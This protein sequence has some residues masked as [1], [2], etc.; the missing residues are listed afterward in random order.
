MGNRGSIIGPTTQT[1]HRSQREPVSPIGEGEEK[2]APTTPKRNSVF[3]AFSTSNSN[4]NFYMSDDEL[5]SLAERTRLRDQSTKYVLDY[6]YYGIPCNVKG[7]IKNG[8]PNVSSPSKRRHTS[9]IKDTFLISDP[10]L[11]FITIDRAE[12]LRNRNEVL[13]VTDTEADV[14]VV[15]VGDEYYNYPEACSVDR[16]GN[17]LVS[18]R[19]EKIQRR[20]DGQA[21]DKLKDRPQ[22]PKKPYIVGVEINSITLG[23]WA[24]DEGT[25]L[26]DQY[27]V[28][29]LEISKPDSG[30]KVLLIREWAREDDLLYC[31]EKLPP[32]TSYRFKIKCRNRVG[33]SDFSEVSEV[34]TTEVYN[35]KGMSYVASDVEGGCQYLY[36]VRAVNK[37][38]KSSW[39]SNFIV[40]VPAEVDPNAVCD[41]TAELRKGHLWLECWDGKDE[42]QFWFHTIT[43]SR[44]LKPPE[45]WVE[46][47]EQLK[48][49]KERNAHMRKE[50]VKEEMDPAVKFRMKRFKFFKELRKHNNAPTSKDPPLNN[51]K[52]RRMHLFSDTLTVFT[53]YGKKDLM[54]KTKIIFNGEEGI[55]SGGLTKD[56]YLGLSRSVKAHKIFAA[57]PSGALEIHPSSGCSPTSLQKFK[58]AGMVLGKALYDRQFLDMPLTKVFYKLI[59]NIDVVTDDLLEVDETLSKSLGWMMENDVSNVIFE[60]FSVEVI[61]GDGRKDRMP[62]CENGENRDVDEDNKAEY[63]KLMAEWRLKFSVMMQL[64]AFKSGLN[65]LVPDHLL[66]Q[67]SIG[68]LELLFNGKKNISVDEIRAYTIY[69]GKIE[70]GSKICLWFWQLLRDF[71]DEGKMKL[72]RFITG[73]DRVPLD[74]F[75]PP[76]NI[77][78][79]EDMTHDMLPRAHTCFNQIVLPRY[80]NYDEMKTKVKT[81]I[82]NTEGFDLS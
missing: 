68:E 28:E 33:W 49:E 38:G 30:F 36:E 76:F 48:L 81:A 21:L 43:G 82:E 15:D 23:W 7:V 65:L 71:D 12:V 4:Q 17:I 41:V 19:D 40:Q 26:V 45:E 60:T 56:W 20:I 34:A 78:D 24:T 10:D 59:L 11:T 52:I 22:T 77:T 72:L 32:N 6:I 70:A 79:G 31:M 14:V 80:K 57:S 61:D 3:Q 16:G 63:V 47:K 50:K 54:K 66:E 51:L 5:S 75:D 25:G 67:F 44:S 37:M 46:Y 55:D 2:K 13:G 29:Y 18:I 9:P 69:Q 58:F 74:G 27:H 39:S 62:L 1:T 73:S 64:E 53:H 35:D 8:S 42:R